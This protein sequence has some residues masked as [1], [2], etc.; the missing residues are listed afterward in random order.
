MIVCVCVC[1]CVGVCVC[2]SAQ[3]DLGE[4]CSLITSLSAGLPCTAECVRAR[5]CVY[6]CV[7]WRLFVC[8]CLCVGWEVVCVCVCVCVSVNVTVSGDRIKL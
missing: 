7:K 8:V 4:Q 2:L 6:I 1:V 5:V 3:D